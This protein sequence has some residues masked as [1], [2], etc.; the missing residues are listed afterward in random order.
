MSYEK[1]LIYFIKAE[2]CKKMFL[3]R[4]TVLYPK[5]IVLHS[6]NINI[7]YTDNSE[8]LLVQPVYLNKNLTLNSFRIIKFSRIFKFFML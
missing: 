6:V 7:Q 5:C 1:Y 3:K 2:Y 8:Q 4:E